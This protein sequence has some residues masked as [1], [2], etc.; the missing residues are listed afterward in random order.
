MK[1]SRSQL[2]RLILES[3]SGSE[4][5]PLDFPDNLKQPGMRAICIWSQEGNNGVK[6][7]FLQSPEFGDS[8]FVRSFRKDLLANDAF[9]EIPPGR[10]L[11]SAQIVIENNFLEP[12]RITN[13]YQLGINVGN[14]LDMLRTPRPGFLPF[15]HIIDI[16]DLYDGRYVGELNNAT[17]KQYCPE[18]H[19]S[20]DDIDDEY[21]I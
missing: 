20:S 15:T 11:A 5:Y 10:S 1:I 7:T 8:S 19:N 21:Y 18:W 9:I 13:P 2:R 12:N 17:I 14:I 3:I 16:Q 6:L 4:S